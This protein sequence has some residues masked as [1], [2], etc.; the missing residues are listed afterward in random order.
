MQYYGSAMSPAD[1]EIGIRQ[2]RSFSIEEVGTSAWKDQRES[3]ERLNMCTH[4]NAV[5]KTDDFVKAFLLEHDKL[6]VV[7][8]E[9]L[10]MEVWR[11]RVLPSIME[12]V[13]HSPTAAYMYCAYESVLVNLLE[14]ICYYEEVV[15]G[16]GDDVL[17]LIDYCWRQVARLFSENNV[18]AIQAPLS[19]TAAE[20]SAAH[21]EQQLRE[22]RIARAMSCISILW[23]IVD[24]LDGLPL[25]AMNSI[26]R[27]NDVLAGMAEVLLLQPW[28]RRSDRGSSSGEVEK[29]QNGGF[30]PAPGNEVQRVCVPEAHAWF[31]LHKFLCDAE[32]RRQYP[33]TQHKKATMLRLRSFLNETLLDQ[34]PALEDVRRALEELSFMEPPTGTEEKF[35]STL[36]IEQV[37][38]LMSAIDT[39]STNWPA[40]AARMNRLLSDR[41]EAVNDAMRMSHVFDLMFADHK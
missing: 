17:E 41:G 13:T 28:L 40:Q 38:R 9:L 32:C 39:P 15:H 35:K 12:A 21:L 16:F 33:Y 8:H 14:C 5:Q 2:L 22:Q 27:K 10:L 6:S 18:N 23:F 34:I 36:I 1:A 20:D 7:L 26:L 25:S 24:R 31:C 37:P 4:S 3:L 30:A 29:Y 19:T 11:Q